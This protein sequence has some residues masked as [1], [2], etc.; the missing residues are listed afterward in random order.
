[1]WYLSKCFFLFVFWK[2]GFSVYP[3]LFRNS[4]CRPGWPGIQKSTCLCLPNA[5]LKVCTTTVWAGCWFFYFVF[6]FKSRTKGPLVTLLPEQ[7]PLLPYR[8]QCMQGIQLTCIFQM[9]QSSA[10]M[11]C[12]ES[13]KQPYRRGPRCV[14][15]ISGWWWRWKPKV[16]TDYPESPTDVS[17]ECLRKQSGSCC[18]KTSMTSKAAL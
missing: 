3:W 7:S 10:V 2:Q 12:V 9:I 17:L 1:M 11:P 16:L 4:L 8:K 13:H 18:H 15:C 5:G 14:A 6:N